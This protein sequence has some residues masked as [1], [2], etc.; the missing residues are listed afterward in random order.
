M[1]HKLVGIILTFISLSSFANVPFPKDVYQVS[2]IM[3]LLRKP[4]I[5]KLIQMRQSY[6][7]E[8][9]EDYTRFFS[10]KSTKCR[11][12]RVIP[13][14]RNILQMNFQ[15][16]IKDT[17]EIVDGM[18]VQ[19]SEEVINYYGCSQAINFREVLRKKGTNLVVH[20]WSSAMKGELDLP[21][22]INETE[23]DYRMYNNTNV[24]IFRLL[25]R[26]EKDR[27]TIDIFLLG[28]KSTQIDILYTA[29]KSD[30]MIYFH[31]LR[32]NYSNNGFTINYRYL[33]EVLNMHVIALK[34]YEQMMYFD[35]NNLRIPFA[36]YVDYFSTVF[37][38]NTGKITSILL[39][40][41]MFDLPSTTFV[42]AGNANSKFLEELRNAQSWLLQRTNLDQLRVI[43]EGYIKAVESNQLQDFRENKTGKNESAVPPEIINQAK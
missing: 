17:K 25:Q 42:N 40:S 11:D 16:K 6:V 7:E 20:S 4:I 39:K 38:N 5:T 23:S 21:I 41:V 9:T 13:A 36:T 29:E 8:P 10:P 43:I 3:D 32:I 12:G 19:I 22:K 18:P 37:I 34:K 26:K 24:E 31:P 27:L 15:K 33:N 14:R 2:Q 28:Q 30:M 1:M 35:G